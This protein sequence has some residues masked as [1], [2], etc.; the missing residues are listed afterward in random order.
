M[1]L[2][3]LFERADSALASI[4]AM[5][6]GA[7]DR[8][9][10]DGKRALERWLSFNWD[11]GSLALDYQNGEGGTFNELYQAFEPIRAQMRKVYGS[12]VLLY[13]G[14]KAGG[15]V[16]DN[17]NRLY[18]WTF[19]EQVAKEYAFPKQAQITEP[20]SDD[21]IQRLLQR[22]DQTGIIR[23]RSYYVKRQKDDP[24]FFDLYDQRKQHITVSDD[25]E[26]FIRDSEQD[27][28]DRNTEME[29]SGSVSAKRIPVDD[30]VW[31]AAN[32]EKEVIV[33]G[34]AK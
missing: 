23:Y 3:Q 9:S 6:K 5:A 17:E 29:E 34:H 31:L 16:P 18:S 22:Y 19:D 28:V 12:D 21:Q 4:Y 10:Y 15:K 20:L 14:M 24:E 8:L 26:Q 33:K 11:T 25:L 1:K 13:R 30:I 2:A 27:I 32:K 7:E